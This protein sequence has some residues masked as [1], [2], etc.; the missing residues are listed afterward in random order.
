MDLDLNEDVC[1]DMIQ[2]DQIGEDLDDDDFLP[3]HRRYAGIACVLVSK[4]K[5]CRELKGVY[6]EMKLGTEPPQSI[7]DVLA[8]YMQVY[9]TMI[10]QAEQV[11]EQILRIATNT[12]DY[13]KLSTDMQQARD[14]FL[15]FMEHTSVAYVSIEQFHYLEKDIVSFL[16]S[17]T[18][19]DVIANNITNIIVNGVKH[20]VNDAEENDDYLIHSCDFL[21]QCTDHVQGI[22][23]AFCQVD[24]IIERIQKPDMLPDDMHITTNLNMA[25]YAAMES[26]D[27]QTKYILD[28]IKKHVKDHRNEF[29]VHE[30]STITPIYYMT[31]L[32]AFS[33]MLVERAALDAMA[34]G[35]IGLNAVA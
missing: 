9:L 30:V 34:Q 10:Q 7:Q 11:I 16:G 15:K 28:Q 35:N 24:G 6:D 1:G 13:N 29:K 2:P 27:G 32:F 21:F 4:M 26:I 33:C 20:I 17:R 3:L 19:D 12:G 18:L 14:E 25:Q 31:Q 5:E 23:Y 22:L 8:G